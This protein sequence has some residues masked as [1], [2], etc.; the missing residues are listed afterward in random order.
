MA[1][2]LDHDPGWQ[3]SWKSLVIL[4]PAVGRQL[5]TRAASDSLQLLRNAYVSFCLAVVLIGVVVV[6]LGDLDP[7]QADRP[8]VAVAITVGVCAAALLLQRVVP[9]PLDASSEATLVASY[10]ARF[11][12]RIAC[13]EACALAGFVAAV[14]FGPR[15]VYAIGLAGA[16][17]GFWFAA[18]TRASLRA[19]QDALSRS[20]AT[21]RLVA[22]L[23]SR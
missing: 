22:S 18:P 11:Y 19:D 3:W 7:E 23:R 1:Q 9:R 15:S 12:L 17:V 14:L 20:G 21:T 16:L 2:D 10:R 6:V 13:A 4:V 8:G 5:A